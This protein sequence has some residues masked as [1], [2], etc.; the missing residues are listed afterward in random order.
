MF[1]PIVIGISGAAG[2]GKDTFARLFMEEMRLKEPKAD[3]RRFALADELKRMTREECLSRWGI[4]ST[5]CEGDA[6][7]IIRPFLVAFG[8][9]KRLATQGKFWTT[10]LE[11]SIRESGV[12]VAVVTDIRYTVYPEDEHWWIT[13][14]MGGVLIHI[15]QYDPETGKNREGAND[16]EKFNEPRLRDFATFKIR[17]PR[18]PGDYIPTL[19]GFIRE[20]CNHGKTTF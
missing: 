13:Q 9:E 14:Q 16:D 17:W 7:T 20:F 15:L 19:R 18:I 4:D 8:K 10:F 2:C 6:K 12:D 11:K 5:T 3:I 1:K